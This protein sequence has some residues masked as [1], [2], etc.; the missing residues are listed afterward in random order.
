[1]N[2]LQQI[3]GEL[4]VSEFLHK[5][6]GQRWFHGR[7]AS[8]QDRFSSLVTMEDLERCLSFGG[9]ERD[10][11]FQSIGGLEG[12]E[13]AEPPRHCSAEEAVHDWLAGRSLIFNGID[14]RLPAIEDLARALERELKCSVWCNLYLTPRRGHAFNTH[15]DTH[16]VFVLQIIGSK[17]WR[18]GGSAIE[19]PL[20][21]QDRQDGGP[22]ISKATALVLQ[23]GDLL[24]VPRGVLHDAV[25]NSELSCHITVGIHAKSYLDLILA[26]VAI[27]ADKEPGFRKYLPPG[28]FRIQDQDIAKATRLLSLI[29]SDDFR[30]AGDAFCELLASDRRRSL[31]GVLRLPENVEALSENDYFQVTPGLMCSISR[32]DDRIQLFAFGR[33]IDLPASVAEDVEILLRGSPFRLGELR[34]KLPAQERITFI[35]RLMLEGIVQ[36]LDRLTDAALHPA[37]VVRH[38]PTR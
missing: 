19:S 31:R 3:L 21:F 1:M 14:R 29:S 11:F 37:D 12:E 18:V 38:A 7:I 4:P 27:A 9:K 32:K 34:A 15:Y 35:G 10:A 36:R 8:L 22:D 13:N 28:S 5:Y 2:C 24:Y 16:D 25:A 17:A 33:S 30:A 23:P 20:P 6:Y 26:A